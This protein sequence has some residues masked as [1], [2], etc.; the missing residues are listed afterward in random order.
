MI[1]TKVIGEFKV[2]VIFDLV[3]ALVCMVKADSLKKIPQFN[4]NN[5]QLNICILNI[6][7]PTIK[8][9]LC[10]HFVLSSPLILMSEI[11]AQDMN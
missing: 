2:S 11:I 6:V 1:K 3:M 10:Y 9:C 5:M 8:C 4:K 7:L